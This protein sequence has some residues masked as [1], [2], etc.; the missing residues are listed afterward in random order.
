MSARGIAVVD[1]GAFP[2]T[3]EASYAITGQPDIVAGSSVRV[4]VTPAQT[5]DHSPDEHRLDAPRVFASLPTAG[6]GFTIYATAQSRGQYGKWSVG[7]EWV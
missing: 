2:G 4:W 5:A 7:W 6:A 3:G 1:L